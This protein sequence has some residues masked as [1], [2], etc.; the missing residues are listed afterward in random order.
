[1]TALRYEIHMCLNIWPM[2]P[3][4]PN[5]KICVLSL[6]GLGVRMRGNFSH[7]HKAASRI[8]IHLIR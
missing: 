5:T 8:C 2:L 1:M 6:A 3:C 4:M 7:L